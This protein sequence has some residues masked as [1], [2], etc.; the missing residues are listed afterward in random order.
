MVGP[1]DRLPL[2]VSIRSRLCE[3]GERL[4]LGDLFP[5]TYVSIRSRLCEAGEPQGSQVAQG[6]T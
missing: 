2:R 4:T 6:L 3:A 1:L 5:E